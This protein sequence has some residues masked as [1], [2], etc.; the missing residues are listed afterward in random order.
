[1]DSDG[2]KNLD[3]DELKQGL[4]AYGIS[5]VSDKEFQVL[6]DYFDRD[7]SGKISTDELLRGLKVILFYYI[8][9]FDFI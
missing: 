2:S 7:K 3:R 9:L 6:F 8:I 5:G 4:I 1:M